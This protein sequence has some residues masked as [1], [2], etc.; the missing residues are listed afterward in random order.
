MTYK[1]RG[2]RVSLDMTREEYSRLTLYLGI[3]AGTA[4]RNENH[5]M[6]YRILAFTNDLNALNPNFAPYEIPPEYSE[7]V[8]AP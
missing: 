3:A 2:V 8:A 6:L 5:T 1:Q 4:N 7:S